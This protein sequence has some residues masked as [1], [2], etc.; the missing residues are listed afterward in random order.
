[1]VVPA[2]DQIQCVQS[3]HTGRALCR[4]HTRGWGSWDVPTHPDNWGYQSDE[5]STLPVCVCVCVCARAC[6]CVCVCACV[7]VCVCACVR[8]RVRGVRVHVRVRACMLLSLILPCL[9]LPS[10]PLSLPLPSLLTRTLYSGLGIM[11]GSHSPSVSSSQSSGFLASGS[12][13]Y[14]GLSQSYEMKEIYVICFSN[15]FCVG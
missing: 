11:G 8:V 14:S 6:V 12:A 10:L 1:M 2:R 5:A 13:M 7:R 15:T 4:L 9:S 3:P